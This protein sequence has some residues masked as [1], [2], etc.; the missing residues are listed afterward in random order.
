M[1]ARWS[2][3]WRQGRWRRRAPRGRAGGPSMTQHL[4]CLTFDYDNASASI[5]REQTTPTTLSRGEFGVVGAAR[6]LDLLAAFAI[7][8]TW[9]IPGHTIETYPASCRA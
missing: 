3:R 2:R 5:A 7:P 4:V 8:S 6:L 9:F 1:P